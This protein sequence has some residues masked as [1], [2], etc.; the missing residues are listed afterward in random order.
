[1]S[2]DAPATAGKILTEKDIRAYVK[3][4]E[5]YSK[6]GTII[7]N[8]GL[9]VVRYAI[10][11]TIINSLRYPNKPISRD[12]Q[13]IV[14][15]AVTKVNRTEKLLEPQLRRYMNVTL[16]WIREFFDIFPIEKYIV[17]SGPTKPRVIVSKTPIKVRVSGIFRSQKRQTIHAIVFTSGATEHHIKNDPVLHLVLKIL[18][19]LVKK[20]QQT[21]RPQVVLHVFGF[22]K[23]N[24]VIYY[25]YD[26]N[27]INETKIKMV[28]SL[29]KTMEAGHHFPVLPCLYSC[30][31]KKECF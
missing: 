27:Y 11:K 6:G 19:P 3:C 13:A 21:D 17:V 30:P 24:N 2:T 16:L 1:M 18:K 25:T 7:P 10:E 29:V 23:N 26:S 12:L 9:R 8:F 5:F 20:H 4:S 22:G 28:E 15:D 31:Y 14:I